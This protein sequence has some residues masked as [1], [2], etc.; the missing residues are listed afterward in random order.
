MGSLFFPFL[1][2][3]AYYV[4]IRFASALWFI[5]ERERER[6]DY[7]QVRK[8]M[9]N[10]KNAIPETK[11]KQTEKQRRLF[12]THSVKYNYMYEIYCHAAYTH[13]ACR[14]TS[15]IYNN[16]ILCYYILGQVGVIT[17]RRRRFSLVIASPLSPSLFFFFFFGP[18]VRLGKWGTN[19]RG[20]AKGIL[21]RAGRQDAPM[22]TLPCVL[23][24]PKH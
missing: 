16:I 12:K 23:S 14:G 20:K 8:D 6:V 22:P 4:Y 17:T 13:V 11:K 3:S 19:K 5:I 7:K 2:G 15:R 24:V 18:L 10:A 21:Q 1:F 9:I